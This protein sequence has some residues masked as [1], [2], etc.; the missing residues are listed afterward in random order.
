VQSGRKTGGQPGHDGQ[1]LAQVAVPDVE[2]LHRPAVCGACQC[3]LNGVAGQVVERRQ[4]HEVPPLKLVVTEHQVEAIRCPQCQAVTQGTF[5]AA[6]GAPAQYGQ[7]VRALAVYLNQYQLL[8]EAR[9]GE[10]LTDLLGCT[11]SDGTV[12]RW[13]QEAA[14]QLAPTVARIADLVAA[15]RVQHTDETGVRMTGQLRWLHVNRTRWLTHLAWHPK[16]GQQA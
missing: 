14:E 1:T 8:P 7:E 5:P 9:T 3:P 15:S 16:R 11:L 4:V 12:A 13:V 2:V 6:V 10:P